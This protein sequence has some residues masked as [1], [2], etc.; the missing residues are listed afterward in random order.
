MPDHSRQRGAPS[1]LYGWCTCCGGWNGCGGA[2]TVEAAPAAT[3][4]ASANV[5]GAARLALR[6][7]LTTRGQRLGDTGPAKVA[8]QYQE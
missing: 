8:Q 6:G 5:S 3:A 2:A 4:D 7:R 1:P